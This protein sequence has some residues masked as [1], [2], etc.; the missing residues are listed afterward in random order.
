MHGGFTGNEGVKTLFTRMTSAPCQ[1][2]GDQSFADLF[3]SQTQW[4]HAKTSCAVRRISSYI[5]LPS[6]VDQRLMSAL[7]GCAL[8]STLHAVSTPATGRPF[9]SSLPICTRTEA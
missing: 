3:S 7:L 1:V 6:L 9:G 2:P 8:S 4:R 5:G